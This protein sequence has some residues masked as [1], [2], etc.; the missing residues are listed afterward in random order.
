MPRQARWLITCFL[1]IA[2]SSGEKPSSQ[3]ICRKVIDGDSCLLEKEGVSFVVRLAGIDAWELS[4]SQRLIRQVVFWKQKGYGVS[5]ETACQWGTN[6]WKTLQKLM[7]EGSLVLF[8]TYGKDHY[9]RV[10]ASL[11]LSNEWINEK[12]IESGWAMVYLPG[13][14]MSTEERQRLFEAEQKARE[15]RQGMWETFQP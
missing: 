4:Y 9:G 12:M 7:P 3:A 11:Y 15:K 13:R 2:C 8:K 10:L 1:L 6:G 14:E 5:Y